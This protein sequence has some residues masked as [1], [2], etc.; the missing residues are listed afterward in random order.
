MLT[1]AYSLGAILG[2]IAVGI[3]LLGVSYGLVR[4]YVIRSTPRRF[5]L[6]AM[7]YPHGDQPY[8]PSFHST[9]LVEEAQRSHGA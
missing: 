6:D 5:R 2:L 4:L 9:P 3:V 1:F 7:H 8:C